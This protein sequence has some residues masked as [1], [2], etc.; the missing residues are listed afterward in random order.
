MTCV[1]T[2]TVH[3]GKVV[4]LKFIQ[5]NLEPSASCSY[6]WLAVNVTMCSWLGKLLTRDKMNC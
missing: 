4:A 6:D 2:I 1:Y 3:P 5:F